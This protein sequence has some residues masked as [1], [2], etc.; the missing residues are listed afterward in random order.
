MKYLVLILAT[1]IAVGAAVSVALHYL[2]S[3]PRPTLFHSQ[4]P[5][6]E[7]LEQLKHL[8]TMRVYI[9]DVLTAEGDGHRGAWLVRGDA[10]LGVDLGRARILDRNEEAK[11]AT[12]S[13]PQPEVLQCRV[14]HERT[15]TWEVRRTTWVPWSGDQDKLRDQVMWE[16]QKLVAR[17]AAS[18]ENLCQ[19]KANA[20]V[21]LRGFY[22]EV[23]WQV[24]VTWET[25]ETKAAAPANP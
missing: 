20:E 9:A 15:R 7:R 22:Q 21:V 23:G 8:V 5:T 13:L 11:Q 1:A 25:Q 19:A 18:S 14:D 2:P 12:L 16:A 10:L 17:A 3:E 4:G 6:V 24:N